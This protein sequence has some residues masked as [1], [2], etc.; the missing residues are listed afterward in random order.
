MKRKIAIAVLLAASA[1]SLAA[2]PSRIVLGGKAVVMVADAAYLFP[3]A[4]D[5]VVAVAAA[6]QGLGLF[7]AALDPGFAA[8]PALDRAAG[9]EAYAALGPDLVIL[10]S[11]MK[12]SVGASLDAL[13]IVQLYLALETPEDYL[14]EIG[15][16][17]DV[18]G[19]PDRARELISFYR[20]SL[21]GVAAKVGSIAMS[22]RPRVLVL[23]ASAQAGGTYEVPP[24]S[25]MQTI[26]TER[27]GG[28][29][30]W[31][32]ANPGSGW[33]R[34]GIEQIAAWDPEAIF[35]ISYREKSSD[36]AAALRTSPALA[37][38][39]AVRA[40]RVF[41][42]PQDFYSW[43]QPDTRWILGL[44]WMAKKLHP[45]RFA[46]VSIQAEAE[47]FFSFCYGM[48]AER[49]ATVVRPRLS[50]DYGN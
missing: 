38:L 9:A 24:A 16:L 4:K 3:Q 23:Q 6:D 7:L 28:A 8:K 15:L 40:G 36:V 42:F 2:T 1:L 27:A 35:V 30:V 22:E 26:M 45:E 44:E 18:F 32:G 48:D 11:A 19:D 29:A 37:S 50:G 47:R 13:G 21:D 17:G 34:V 43:D 49:Y 33:A 41:G 25:W 31:K 12:K 14:R 46:E 20:A 5:R 39:S 10:K